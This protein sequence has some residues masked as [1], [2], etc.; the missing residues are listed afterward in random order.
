LAHTPHVE[1]ITLESESPSEAALVE[2]VRLVRAVI[3]Q[4]LN[5]S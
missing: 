4:K 1:A 2:E 5:R 3:D